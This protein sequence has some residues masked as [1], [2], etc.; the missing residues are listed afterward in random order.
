MLG[1][2][3]STEIKKQLPK[4]LLAK[5]LSLKPEDRRI[6]DE[7]ISRLDLVNQISPATIPALATGAKVKS[8]FVLRATLKKKK[9]DG[10]ALTLIA[11][12]IPQNLILLLAFEGE[13]QLAVLHE[14]MLVSDWRSNAAW[15]DA[16][17]LMLKGG[18]L[19]AVWLGL[20]EQISGITIP[21][22]KEL[23][24]AAFSEE[25][26]NQE[27]REKLKKKISQLEKARRTEIQPRRKFDLHCKIQQLT[28]KLNQGKPE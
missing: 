13:S 14:K 9:Y 10:K 21:G 17:P 25:L 22:N 3:T 5:K 19:D 15:D 11:K 18:D 23:T 1:L 7:N 27:E 16:T 12:L 26:H 6:I 28:K 8:I 2:P 4:T 20:K 24:D